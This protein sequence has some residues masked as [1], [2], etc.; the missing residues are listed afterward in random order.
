MLQ[1]KHKHILIVRYQRK[2]HLL[3]DTV[4]YN[5]FKTNYVAVANHF[6]DYRS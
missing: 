4:A 5:M 3:H 6:P 2:I 1:K